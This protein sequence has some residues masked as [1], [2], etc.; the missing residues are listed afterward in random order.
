MG[1]II[2]R[3][4]KGMSNPDQFHKHSYLNIETYRKTGV[5]IRTPVWFVQDGPAIYV[6]TQADSGKVKRIRNNPR[7][8]ITPCKVDGTPL[9]DWVPAT[10][11]ELKGTANEQ[12]IDRLFNKKYGLQKKLFA[13][14]GS[15]Q[16]RKATILE[17]KLSQE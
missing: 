5:G 13:L 12:E 9:G 4:M 16:R 7:V 8:M 10:A 6:H 17:I 11:R 15:L 14:V 2:R 1:I 3:T